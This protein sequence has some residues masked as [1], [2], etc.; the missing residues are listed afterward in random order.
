MDDVDSRKSIGVA[1][2]GRSQ[3]LIPVW[4]MMRAVSCVGSL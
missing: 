2:P 1:L 4:V 3:D